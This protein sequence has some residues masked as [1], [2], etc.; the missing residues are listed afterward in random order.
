MTNDKSKMK[1]ILCYYKY[2]CNLYLALGLLLFL[3]A[4][5]PFIIETNETQIISLIWS[6]GLFLLSFIMIFAYFYHRQTLLCTTDKFVLSNLFGVMQTLEPKNCIVE[7]VLL[8]TE[9]S[10]VRSSNKK[11]ICIYE[12]NDSIVKFKTGVSNSRK[13]ARVQVIFNETNESIVKKFLTAG[14]EDV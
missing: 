6:I 3:M 8:P 5:L 2:I 10:W 12:K 1:K 13:H 11:W 9:Y 14:D 7:I 4:I